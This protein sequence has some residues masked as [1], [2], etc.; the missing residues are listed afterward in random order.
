MNKDKGDYAKL[1][2]ITFNGASGSIRAS[3]SIAND[4]VYEAN[5]KRRDLTIV[6]NLYLDK[7]APQPDVYRHG[8][9]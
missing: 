1:N 9:S 7:S 5:D 2:G 6:N 3:M 8:N 4:G